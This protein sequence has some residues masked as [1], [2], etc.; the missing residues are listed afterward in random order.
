MFS[1]AK[2]G[3]QIPNLASTR[4]LY[5]E[6]DRP[7]DGSLDRIEVSIGFPKMYCK[8]HAGAYLRIRHRPIECFFLSPLCI[9][10]YSC[11][12]QTHMDSSGEK[13]GVWFYPALSGFD[14]RLDQLLLLLRGNGKHIDQ[15]IGLLSWLLEIS[16]F[17]YAVSRRYKEVYER[18]KVAGCV[19]LSR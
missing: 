11:L 7:P 5:L 1:K 2:T 15:G 12:I 10:G 9:I 13:T 18:E 4:G 8:A 14:Q 17:E 19:C 3:G 16:V 6:R